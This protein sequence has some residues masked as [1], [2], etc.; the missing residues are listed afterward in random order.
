MVASGINIENLNAND[1]LS[2]PQDQPERLFPRDKSGIKS[3]FRKLSK[4]WHPD[5]NPGNKAAS[6]V[7]AHI[8]RLNESAK[9]KLESG[10][11]ETPGVFEIKQKSGK[12][13]KIQYLK[14]QKFELGEFFICKDKLLYVIDKNCADFASNGI[15][16]I[17]AFK[18]PNDKIKKQFKKQ[19][20]QNTKKFE[21]AD[22]RQVIM[23]DRDPQMILLRDLL[24]SQGGKIDPKQVAWIMSRLHNMTCYLQA[25]GLTHNA[26]TLDTV[27][28]LPK[29]QAY[30]PTKDK[31]ISDKD[32]TIALLGGWWYASKEGDALTGLPAEAVSYAPR[33]VLDEGRADRKIDHTLIRIIG[34]QLLG[35]ITGVR[36]ARDKNIPKPMADWLTLPGSGDA[37]KDF[38]TWQQKVLIN[39][40]GKRRYVEMNVKASDIYKPQPR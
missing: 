7:F 34:R 33:D 38:E 2:I 26:I 28:V 25:N 22:G 16:A 11:W 1:I 29:D 32:H 6:D 15:N 40:F 12:T 13:A 23:M 19:L 4:K 5:T 17:K 20:P 18:Y 21:A 14:K 30:K 9:D 39:S 27:F 10:R 8:S 24:D 31:P 35:D 36:L 37:M 3:I